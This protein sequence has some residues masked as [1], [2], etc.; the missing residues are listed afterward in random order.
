MSNKVITDLRLFAIGDQ[1]AQK[2]NS[3]MELL[4]LSG[5]SM[6]MKVP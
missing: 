2:L 5:Q 6:V 1:W 4:S 3:Q